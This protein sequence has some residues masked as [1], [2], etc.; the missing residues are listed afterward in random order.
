MTITLLLVA[1][2]GTIT[3]A[4]TLDYETTTYYN[5]TVQAR[6]GGSPSRSGTVPVRIIIEDYNDCTPQFTQDQNAIQVFENAALG[7]QKHTSTGLVADSNHTL[8]VQ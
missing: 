8:Q 4:S 3:T 5:L 1:N 7:K 6:D 2:S